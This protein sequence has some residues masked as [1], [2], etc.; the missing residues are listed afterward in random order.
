MTIKVKKCIFGASDCTYLGYQIGRG[1]V[2][3]EQR[4]IEAILEMSRPQTKKEVK[5]ILE[6]TGYY[7]RFV[8]NY[9]TIN[10]PLTEL[11]RKNLP[12]IL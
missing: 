5:T 10:E 1:G 2:K 11:T 9:A 4:K 7:R 3:P 8:Q 6:I 12:K